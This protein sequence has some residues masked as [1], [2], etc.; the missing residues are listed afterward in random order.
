M[1]STYVI[2]PRTT[3]ENLTQR[4]V[5]SQNPINQ[6]AT[7]NNIQRT[8]KRGRKEGRGMKKRGK[9]RTNKKMLDL[10]PN[11]ISNCIKCNCLKHTNKKIRGCQND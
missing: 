6:N 10:N 5:C 1:F 11:I 7:L 8:L 9:W 4:D 3:S 2:I